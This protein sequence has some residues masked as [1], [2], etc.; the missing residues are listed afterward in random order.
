MT[1][2]Y[3]TEKNNALIDDQAQQLIC[4]ATI[5]QILSWQSL[6]D[7]YVNLK[8]QHPQHSIL[9]LLEDIAQCHYTSMHAANQDQLYFD[10]SEIIEED[11]AVWENIAPYTLQHHRQQLLHIDNQITLS[12]LSGK[13]NYT[14]DDFAA[15]VQINQ[16]PEA[17]LAE[18]VEVKLVSKQS[19]DCEKF[20]AQINGYFSCDLNPFECFALVQYLEREFALEYLGLGASLLFFVKTAQ[21]DHNKINALFKQLELIYLF[22][23]VIT[24]QLKQ[25]LLEQQHLILPYVESLEMFDFK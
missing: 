15:L 16:H 3:L 25:L 8:Q 23:E 1:T 5:Q 7:D 4:Y 18:T 19:R 14:D 2:L 13:L 12:Q 21:F 17:I 9:L 11:D 22:P 10:P 6:L 20:A 24:V